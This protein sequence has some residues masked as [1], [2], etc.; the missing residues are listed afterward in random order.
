[1]DGLLVW[2]K[3]NQLFEILPTASG[4]QFYINGVLRNTITTNTPT[5]VSTMG[6]LW[7]VDNKNTPNVVGGAVMWT[8]VLL[9]K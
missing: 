1:M 8:M 5:L 9:N 6:Q 2:L 7:T 3:R 4:Y